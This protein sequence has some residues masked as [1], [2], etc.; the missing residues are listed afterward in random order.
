MADYV[1][2]HAHS[3]YSLLDGASS[4]DDLIQQ[5][6]AL[7]MSALALTDHDGV[8]GAVEFAQSARHYQIRPIFGAELTLDNGH[9]LTLLVKDKIGWH[10]LCSLITQARHNA[11]KGEAAL[12]FDALQ[13]HTQGLIALSGCR[14]GEINATLLQHGKEAARKVINRYREVFDSDCLWIELQHHYLPDDVYYLR[15]LVE[16]ANT[17]GL[18]YVATNNVHYASREQQRLQD[19]LACIKHQTSLDQAR[20]LLRPNSEYYL[21]SADEMRTLFTDYPEAIANSFW[22]AD[23]C[24]WVLEYGLQDL[25][26]F[27]TP[28]EISADD[29]LYQLCA[30]TLHESS[31]AKLTE[32]QR[33]LRHELTVI[34]YAHLAN[35]FLIVWDMVRFA[36]EKGIRCQGR[37]SAANSV[38]AY[39]LGITPVNPLAHALVFERFLSDER[40]LMPDIDIDFDADRREEVIQYIYERYGQDHAAMACTVVTFRTRSAIRD[41]GKALGF[42]LALLSE[43]RD[44]IEFGNLARDADQAVEASLWSQLTDLSN[45][46]K[47]FPRHLGIH[48]GGMVIT[49]ALLSQRL[50]T[51]PATMQDR[52]VVQWDKESLEDAGLIKIDI[53][54][55]R[56][57]S[58]ISET[59]EVI[60]STTGEGIDLDR[61]TFDDPKVFE[62]LC[63]AD[64]VGVFQVESRAQAQVLPRLQPRVFNDLIISISL[65]RPGPVQ[66]NM[67]HPYLR[68][69][70]GVEAIDCFHPRL[71]AALQETLGVILFQEQV[72]KVAH[73]LAGFSPGQGELLR[74]ALGNK[75]AYEAIEDLHQAFIAGAVA[76]GVEVSIA[77]TV[78]DKLRAFGGYSFPKSH[79]AA[80]AV[81]VYQSAWLKYYYPAA[82]Y[83]G[84]LNHQPMGFWTPAVLTADAKRHGIKTL[85]VDLFDSEVRCTL[86]DGHIRLGFNY[87]KQLGESGGQRIVDA[88]QDKI[89]TNL[90]DFCQRTNLPR[91]VVE[92]LILVGAMDR[93]QIPRRQLLWIFGKLRYPVVE[94]GLP[95]MEDGVSLPAMTSEEMMG[96]EYAIL[97]LSPRMHP[98]ESYRDWLQHN[99]IFNSQTVGTYADGH[100]IQVAGLMVVQQSPHTAKGFVFLTLEDEFGFINVVVR[101]RIFEDYH[102]I[103]RNSPLLL[104]MGTLQKQGA[105][106]NVVAEVIQ[107]LLSVRR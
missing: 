53:L 11:P 103:I 42:P 9:H 95:E 33:Q 65:I 55:L 71:A 80:F 97:G 40:R 24:Q 63:R 88:R 14:Q 4:P 6:A 102:Q 46:I 18:G 43:A 34:R 41:V 98:V 83:V 79:A 19:V 60:Q 3:Y 49:D 67:V 16:L 26:R 81:L 12:P 57:L 69:R 51:E 61:L 89:F 75:N 28:D 72:L 23:Q 5:A 32:M 96:M 68:R 17:H 87:I 45:Q 2:L 44:Y 104:V 31:G 82:F 106:I 99:G 90:N 85:S 30:N 8:Y 54:G 29:Y 21:K 74:R 48:N 58:A 70:L 62:M 39:L 101:P 100:R 50:P 25:P 52:V 77:E 47:G 94:L 13:T 7:G 36:R 37:G 76:N 35:Y 93:W 92:N 20:H 107:P 66:G 86:E 38:V 91:R 105:V 10:N 59:L 73:D 22:I 1:E 78:F 27:P 64:T 84:L 56:M 15:A